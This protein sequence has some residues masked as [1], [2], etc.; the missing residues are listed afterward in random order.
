[1]SR[2]YTLYQMLKPHWKALGS[3][4]HVIMLPPNRVIPPLL[5]VAKD[6]SCY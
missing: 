3:P 6:S 1:M 2:E 4:L 5:L